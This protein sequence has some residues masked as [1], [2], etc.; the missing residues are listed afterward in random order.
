MNADLRPAAGLARRRFLTLT[1]A[2]TAVA[3]GANLP[4]SASAYRGGGRLDADPFTLGVASGDPL[5]DAVVIWTR[6][7]PRPFEPLGGAPYRPVEV[8]WQVADDERFRRVVRAG[9]A[10]ARPEYSHSVHV[11]VRGL[12]PGR[13]YWYRF[14]AGGYL[15]P[16]GR[17]R[18][19]PAAGQRV[20]RLTIAM[21]S[22]QSWPDGYYTAH[23]HLAA[24]DVDAVVFLGDY[25]YEYGIAAAGGLRA[26]TDPVP[27]QFRTEADTLDRYRL[28]YA[29]YKSDPDLQA[30]HAAA[31]WIVTWDDH[32]VQDNYA[33]EVSKSNAPVLDFLVRRANAYRAYWEHMPLRAPAPRGP[34][35]M[36]YRR[37]TFGRLAEINVLDTRQYRSDQASGDGWRADSDARRDPGRSLAGA[38]Q[39]RWLLDGLTGS[40]A[41]WNLLANQVIMSRMDLD[42]TPA[43]LYNMDAWDG[44]AAQQRRLLDGLAAQRHRNPVVL[45]GDVHAA[46]AMDMKT[47]FA[48]PGSTSFGVEL[49]ATSISSGGNGTDVSATGRA[50]LAAN[51]HLKLVDERRGY[52]VLRL[53]EG[54]MRVDYRAVPYIDRTGAPVATVA[55]FVVEAGN[56]GLNPVGQ[57]A[58]R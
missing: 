48:D 35:Y 45:T 1:G 38:Q 42:P 14:K 4:G 52:T 44:Y 13:H 49:V 43:D 3:F 18:T 24:E 31:P 16:T 41:T 56:P 11:D 58:T 30:A 32:E 25:L 8:E 21:G 5:P 19:A 20:D 34:N 40:H 36:L 15:S 39:E 51:P 22:C 54:E 53:T 2:A 27:S 50:F 37:L 47:D 6:L 26:V 29:L 10:Q 46:Y 12:R 57:E 55:S 28:Q 17:T 33:G 9:R 7:A 23:R